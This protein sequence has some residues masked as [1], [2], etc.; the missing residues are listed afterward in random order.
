[1]QNNN[2]K[3]YYVR[4]ESPIANSFLCTLAANSQ[5]IN[6]KEKS[7]HELTVKADITSEYS[8]G[9]IVGSSGS[10]KTSLAKKIFGDFV[11][12]LDPSKPIID[13]FPTNWS[14]E[15][16]CNTIT[17]VGLT[18][19]PCWI[20]PAY[21]LSN[22]QKFRAEVALQLAFANPGCPSVIDEWTSVVDRNVAKVM[23]YSVNKFANKNK[24][25]IVLLSCHYDVIEW[26]DPDWI[27]DCNTQEFIDRRLLRPGQRKRTETMQFQVAEC[28]RESWSSFSKYHY[29]SKNLAVGKQFHFGLFQG[30][31]QVGYQ[32][33]VNYVPKRPGK[34]MILHSNRLVI[35][36]DF[37]GF[38]LG[39]KFA[40]VT[41]EYIS[42]RGF[43]V[44]AA[45]SSKAMLKNRLKDANWKLMNVSTPI[46]AVNSRLK[47]FMRGIEKSGQR[48]NVKFYSFKYVGRVTQT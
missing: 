39:M 2:L 19:V 45:F 10:G 18:S 23:S 15:Q 26:L 32:C 16:I 4:L 30:N 14:Y 11:N 1:M 6:Q 17:G 21:T 8:I 7:I 44:F 9:L 35:H 22:G 5:D 25:K 47:R 48:R 38:G 41:A 34:K 29:L 46:K 42:K 28:N 37:V 3:T 36:P 27:I 13:Q 24:K 12:I 40:N 31:H 33:Y 20:R 43:D